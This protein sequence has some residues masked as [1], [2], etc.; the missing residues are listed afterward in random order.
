MNKK[1]LSLAVAAAVAAPAVVLADATL[2]GKAHVSLDYLDLRPDKTGFQG[3]AMSRGR[4]GGTADAN[5]LARGG[6][7]RASRV[8]VK[9]SEDLGGLKGIY[10]VEFG[11]PLANEDDYDINDGDKDSGVKMRNSYIGLQGDFGTL[12]AGRHDTP[13]KMSTSRLELFN[14][15]MADNENTV[16]FNDIRAD[17]T[18]AYLSPNW[19]GFRFAAA[20]MPGAASTIHGEKNDLSDN[21]GEGYSGAALYSNGPWHMSLAYEL[22]SENF[23]STF[24]S[25]PED[26]KKWRLGLGMLDVAGF[27]LT[28]LYE[29]WEGHEFQDKEADL[30][31]IQAGYAFG[32][33]MFKAMYGK[34][35]F[36]KPKTTGEIREPGRKSWAVGFD[37]NF[38]KRTKAY[39]LYTKVDGDSWLDAS[40][41]RGEEADW[42]GFSLG[43][44]HDF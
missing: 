27:T 14:D 16:G 11:V 15:R 7:S 32:N 13:F 24:T 30:W 41:T 20:I 5:G 40:A 37:H 28:G 36:D 33:N 6:N 10:Q 38:S 17:S 21:L 12:L 1:L 3:W 34:T 9:G 8:G 18:V 39:L 4:K 25:R 31:Q 19:G 44:I 35:S 43:M 42:K 22:L 2:Y 23:S 29:K 26:Y